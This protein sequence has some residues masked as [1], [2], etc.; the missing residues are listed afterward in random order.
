MGSR[1]LYIC[2]PFR[3]SATRSQRENIAA[4]NA[5]GR[6][7]ATQGWRV[8]VPHNLSG[9]MDPF[10]RLGDDYWLAVTLGVMEGCTDIALCPGWRESQ[11][12]RSEEVRAREL[13]MTIIE[14]EES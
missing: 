10:N 3:A 1:L 14:V 6:Y 5:F 9:E 12:C 11:G 7:F 2:S 8:V 4:A 13:G